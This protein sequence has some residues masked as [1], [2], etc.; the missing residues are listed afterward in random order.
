MEKEHLEKEKKSSWNQQL[1]F[2]AQN[3]SGEGGA[4]AAAGTGKKILYILHL[5]YIHCIIQ[6]AFTICI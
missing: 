3:V 2:V 6:Y 5:Q 1:Q 4:A